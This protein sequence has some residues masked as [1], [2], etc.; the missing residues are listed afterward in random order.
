MKNNSDI[1]LQDEVQ[2]KPKVTNKQRLLVFIML[3]IA[4]A[5]IYALFPAVAAAYET[6]APSD[7]GYTFYELVIENGLNGPIGFVIGA[8]LLINA[9][10][11]IGSNPKLAALQA[12]GGGVLIKAEAVANS[13]G[14]LV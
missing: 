14:F 6:P 9:G 10:T 3:V 5:V 12:V 4:V 1:K 11:S 7:P 2:G 8:W 13:L